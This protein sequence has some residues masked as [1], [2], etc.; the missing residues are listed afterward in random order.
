M[1]VVGEESVTHRPAEPRAPRES[2]TAFLIPGPFA[3]IHHLRSPKMKQSDL[4]KCGSR[5]SMYSS[6]ECSIY[7]EEWSHRAR[8]SDVAR[9]VIT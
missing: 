3:H 1:G 9:T 7:T 6:S 8:V 2:D 5:C 4:V